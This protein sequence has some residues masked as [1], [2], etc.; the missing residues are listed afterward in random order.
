MPF[1]ND[2]FYHVVFDPPHLIKLGKSS[3]MAK[4]YGVLNDTWQ[5]DL[6]DGMAECMRVLKPFGTLVFKWNEQQIKT[7]DLIKIL[8]YAP[9]YGH[10]RKDSKTVWMVFMKLTT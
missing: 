4:K 1:G 8:G 10:K 7:S 3:W 6:K 9:L 5:K 2:T